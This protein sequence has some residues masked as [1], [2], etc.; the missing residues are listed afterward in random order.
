MNSTLRDPVI[1][2]E[3]CQIENYFIGPFSS[4]GDRAILQDADLEHSV[5]L[6]SAQIIGIQQRIVDSVIGQRAKLAIAP[7]RPKA[8]RFLIGDDS[9]IELV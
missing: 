8:L 4:I 1:I 6:Q 2:S 3:N 9:Q 7:Q 5:M